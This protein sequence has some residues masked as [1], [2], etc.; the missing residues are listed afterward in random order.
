MLSKG[1]TKL[2]TIWSWNIP[3]KLTCPGK[4]AVCEAI[5]Y[6]SRRRYK[7]ANV[8]ESHRRNE[9]LRHGPTW[10]DDLVAEIAKSR[11]K[12]LR[13]HAAGD[14][15]TVDYVVNWLQ[16]VNRCP[17]TTFY[18]YT[19]SWTQA[20]LKP[21]LVE[22]GACD[23]FELWFSWDSSMEV[24]PDIPGIRTC[25]LSLNDDDEP[26]AATDL[27]FREKRGRSYK[28]IKRKMGVDNSQVCPHETGINYKVDMSC[29]HCKICFTPARTRQQDL[30]QIE[31]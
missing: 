8:V 26:S 28:S 18:A 29:S 23:N 21:W 5:C 4:S 10:V 25:Y 17:D 27:V 7:N 3:A 13:I 19:R 24:P 16:I 31:A 12:V 11:V 6:A 30:V 1:N 9:Q 22:L 14:F 15:D 20:E 2:G